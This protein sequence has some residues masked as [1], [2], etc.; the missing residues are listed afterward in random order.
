[1][2]FVINKNQKAVVFR[3]FVSIIEKQR[4]GIFLRFLMFENEILDN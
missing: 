2:R 1:M 4:A 3:E